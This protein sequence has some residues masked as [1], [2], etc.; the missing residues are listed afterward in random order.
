MTR[1]AVVGAGAVGASVAAWLIAEPRHDVTLCTRTPF[2]RLHVET[3]AGPLDSHPLVLTEP[4]D[5]QPV[6]WVIA[7]TKTYDAPGVSRWLERLADA[8]THVAILQNGVE[9]RSRFPQL[10]RARVVPVVVDIPAERHAPGM[11]V[12]RRTGSMTV[13][14]DAAGR[15]FAA[16]FA[17]SAIELRLTDDWLTAAWAKLAVNCAGAINALTLRSAEIAHDEEAAELMRALVREC[18]AVGRAEGARLADT[19]PDDV[20]AGYRAAPGDSLNSIHADRLAGRQTEADAR[21]GVIARLGERHGID[22]P[23]NRMAATL[24]KLGG[25]LP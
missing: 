15:S 21:N 7:A 3:P 10:D 14:D 18:V 19:L 13:P 12:Q 17:H 11:V 5:A 9:H 6:D 1:I 8:G 2:E 23:L 20:V 22:A 16:L 4:A 25:P 24:L